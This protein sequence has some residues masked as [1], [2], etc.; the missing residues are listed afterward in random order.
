MRHIVIRQ[1]LGQCPLAKRTK[2][3][4]L[5]LGRQESECSVGRCKERSDGR[6]GELWF[7]GRRV[8][9]V[10]S[11]VEVVPA[12]RALRGGGQGG[13]EVREE[14]EGFKDR[15]GRDEGVVEGVEVAVGGFAVGSEDLGVKVELDS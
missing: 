1:N 7:T 12:T 9:T 3:K 15:S 5:Q 8:F 4:E 14:V 6:A 13:E 11:P 2:Q 10:V